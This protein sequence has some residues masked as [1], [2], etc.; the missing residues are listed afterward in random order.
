MSFLPHS[1][2]AE[3]PCGLSLLRPVSGCPVPGGRH[4]QGEKRG[5]GW[6]MG[7]RAGN[8]AEMNLDGVSQEGCGD[9][10]AKRGRSGVGVICCLGSSGSIS[11]VS[12]SWGEMRWRV[13]TMDIQQASRQRA[14]EEL[15]TWSQLGRLSPQGDAVEVTLGF[16]WKHRGPCCAALF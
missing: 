6:R 7:A 9:W 5:L 13:G 11:V 4:F 8:M 1:L 3:G 14:M 2:S 10:K 12:S 15:G 16:E